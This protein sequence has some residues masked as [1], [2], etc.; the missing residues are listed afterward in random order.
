MGF[1]EYRKATCTMQLT[2]QTM[3]EKHPPKEKFQHQYGLIPLF[4]VRNL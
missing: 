1:Q 3:Y 2:F 4:P